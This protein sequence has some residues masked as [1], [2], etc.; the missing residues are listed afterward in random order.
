MR[1]KGI[2]IGILLASIVCVI[3]ISTHNMDTRR[4]ERVGGLIPYNIN[5]DSILDIPEEY[6]LDVNNSD[7]TYEELVAEIGEPSGM[8][9]SGIV[10]D[11]WRIGEDK[12]AVCFV[13]A[14]KPMF[15]IWD[16][17]GAIRS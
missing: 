16:G 17:Q 2:I 5:S 7:M 1:K 4:T 11:Y 13:G 12:Y 14:G 6:F 10:R 8:V 15:E 3:L 9:G